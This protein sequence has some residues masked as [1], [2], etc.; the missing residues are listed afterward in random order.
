MKEFQHRVVTVGAGAAVP[1]FCWSD[2]RCQTSKKLPPL[3]H[4]VHITSH[5]TVMM[6]CSGSIASLKDRK[7]SCGVARGQPAAL[8]LH[9][10]DIKIFNSSSSKHLQYYMFEDFVAVLLRR[11]EWVSTAEN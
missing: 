6:L 1:P 11:I 5:G 3:C 10:T 7:G 2:V 4:P 8:S 9:T